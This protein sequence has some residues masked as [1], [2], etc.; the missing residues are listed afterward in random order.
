MH[1]LDG[2]AFVA[3]ARFAD[4]RVTYHAR[5]VDLPQYHMEKAAGRLLERRPFTNR[6]GGRFANL[7]RLAL[8]TGSS[9]DV[10][11]WGG[12]V[13][14]ADVDAH[15]LLDATNLETL[16]P[17]P[18][19]VLGGGIAQ[20]SA[21]PRVDPHT[22]NLVAYVMNPGV[23]GSDKV[24]IVEYDKSWKEVRRLERSLGVKGAVLHDHT[25]TENHYL[26][27]QI[28]RLNVA[29]AAGGG[30]SVIRAVGVPRGSARIIAIPRQGHGPIRSMPLPDNH[31]T[32]HI[33]NA[34]EVGGKLIV[35]TAIYDGPPD[36]R[37]LNPPG[38]RELQGA[39]VPSGGPFLARHTLDLSSG[40]HDVA[41][42]HAARGEAPSVRD[43]LH[44]RRHR[45]AYASAPGSRG[46]EPV[47]FAYYWYHAVSKLDC[48]TGTT[49][50]AW[51]AGPRVFVSAPQVVGRSETEDDAWVLAWTHDAA[52][53]PGRARHPRR[54]RPLDGA[55][56]APLDARS[57][58]ATEPCGLARHPVTVCTK[59][60]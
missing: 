45:Y 47:D 42:H 56:R 34:Y 1:F 35:D 53:W 26:V 52:F 54:P 36:F 4:G 37:D 40:A 6:P 55:C 9:H 51:D 2:Y 10:Y 18:L 15:Y 7:F 14:A 49:L 39:S 29:K 44:G 27:V 50:S 8:R 33:A 28:G 21:M 31:Q 25:A 57:A 46:D 23:I 59:F 38:L 5:N 48:D 22:G 19:N 12:S 60:E 32:F 43:D 58:A 11:A 3:T 16:G 13:V 17:A 30:D 20:L 41:V 24:F